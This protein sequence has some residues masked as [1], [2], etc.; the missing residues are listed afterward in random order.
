MFED[1]NVQISLEEIKWICQLR[2][3]A[4]AGPD[5]FLNEFLKKG[6]NSLFEYLHNLFNKIFELFFFRKVG[7]KGILFLFLKRG[8]RMRFQIIA[9]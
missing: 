4:S 1:L 9:A 2:N 7:Q 6:T 5:F 3:G 8:T